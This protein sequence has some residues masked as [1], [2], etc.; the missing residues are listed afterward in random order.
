L[1]I[2]KAKGMTY[3]TDL[4]TLKMYVQRYIVQGFKENALEEL[5]EN[6]SYIY[7]AKLMKSK[8]HTL[9]N[10]MSV[11]ESMNYY[12]S[13]F[14]LMIL[15]KIAQVRVIVVGRKTKDNEQGIAM[16]P[17]QYQSK[18]NRFIVMCSSYDRFNHHDVYQLAVANHTSKTPKIIMRK[19]EVSLPLLKL[20]DMA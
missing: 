11:V 5:Y 1:G 2:C 9:D 20:V 7:N 13:E 18:Y 16:Y 19:H 8:A 4:D 3:I 12:P 17:D 14:E 10:I 6:P 15:V